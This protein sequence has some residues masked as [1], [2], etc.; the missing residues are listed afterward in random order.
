MSLDVDVVV[1]VNVSVLIE[2]D[3]DNVDD[4]DNDDDD[5]GNVDD[6]VDPN[7]SIDTEMVF[8][9]VSVLVSIST[10]FVMTG[11]AFA[12]VDV[13]SVINVDEPDG[14]AFVVNTLDND[15]VDAVGLRDTVD[16]DAVDGEGGAL[17]VVIIIDDV[18]GVLFV[19]MIDAVD[20][21][22]GGNVVGGGSVGC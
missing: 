1:V 2:E 17:F 14:S 12:S 10:E 18:D 6:N 3:D 5:A 22:D 21:V 19:E 16:M 13:S 9:L 8:I 7:E 20:D 15:D 11:V 4:V